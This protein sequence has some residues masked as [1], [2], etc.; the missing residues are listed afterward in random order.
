MTATGLVIK[1]T[2]AQH[3]SGSENNQL[4]DLI[5]LNQNGDNCHTVQLMHIAHLYIDRYLKNV[6]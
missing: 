4:T 5:I 6:R 1:V 2:S 3:K